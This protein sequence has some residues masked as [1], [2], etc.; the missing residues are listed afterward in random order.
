MWQALSRAGIEDQG[1]REEIAMIKIENIRPESVHP[2]FGGLYVHAKKLS[3]PECLLYIAGQVGVNQD[4]TFGKDCKEQLE[5]AWRNVDAILS[6]AGMSKI[7]I[8]E[9]FVFINGAP[10]H[11]VEA[12][13]GLYAE[14]V[15]E[16][17]G[18]NV[19]AMSA[20]VSAG[21][22]VDELCFEFKLVAAK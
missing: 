4:G 13:K 19:P 12:N 16:Y 1:T 18:E 14:S 3:N 8:V 6:E 7:N 10:G 2:E 11:D 21:L 22:W 9:V 15:T 17:F 5:I 20:L